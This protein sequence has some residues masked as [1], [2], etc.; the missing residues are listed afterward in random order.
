MAR[1]KETKKFP[2]F[3]GRAYVQYTTSM[4]E[5]RSRQIRMPFKNMNPIKISGWEA[6]VIQR[7]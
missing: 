5:P 4:V 2:L 7:H 1:L 6:G 3:P